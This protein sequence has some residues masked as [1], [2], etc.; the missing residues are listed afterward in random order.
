MLLFVIL[1]GYAGVA[2]D[3]GGVVYHHTA[4]VAA[5]SAFVGATGSIGAGVNYHF[6][7]V[8]LVWRP[9]AFDMGYFMAFFLSFLSRA[10]SGFILRSWLSRST[11]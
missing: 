9:L 10:A 4:G 2:V 5:S 11:Q 3:G 8:Y 1:D 6:N 7:P